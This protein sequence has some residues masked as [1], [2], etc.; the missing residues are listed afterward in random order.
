VRST[1]GIDTVDMA[2]Y[3]LSLPEIRIPDLSA[4][5]VVAIWTVP[6]LVLQTDCIVL[7]SGSFIAV[8]ATQLSRCLETR[9]LKTAHILHRTAP[10]TTHTPHHSAHSQH[11]TLCFLRP[12]ATKHQFFALLKVVINVNFPT[13]KALPYRT[14]HVGR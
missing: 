10:H 11:K 1:A 3:S 14:E 4:R 5:N 8:T 9:F 13:N 7:Q 2:T 6:F 12:C